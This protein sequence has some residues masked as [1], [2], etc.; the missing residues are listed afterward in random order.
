MKIKI[1]AVGCLKEP[2]YREGQKLFM[3][4]INKRVQ[5][6][7]VEAPQEKSPESLS[8]ALRNSVKQTEGRGVLRHIHSIDKVVALEIKGKPLDSSALRDML[9]VA[10]EG[11]LTFVIGGS[12]GLG[13]N[14]LKRAD[15]KA[16]FSSLTFPHQLMRIMLLEAISLALGV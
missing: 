10:C 3:R 15:F 6:E 14:V 1:I 11:A 2:Y 16:S 7:V 8:E 13:E 12:L 9:D 4:E 5:I